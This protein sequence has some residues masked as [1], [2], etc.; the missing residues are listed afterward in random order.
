M[1]RSDCQRQSHPQ[2][3]VKSLNS[4]LIADKHR[5]TLISNKS[6]LEKALFILFICVYLQRI[7]FKQRFLNNRLKRHVYFITRLVIESCRKSIR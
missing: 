4:A 5:L 1:K 7:A 3:V 2:T 6:E